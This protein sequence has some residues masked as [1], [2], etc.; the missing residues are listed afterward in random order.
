MRRT[1]RN[2]S[3]RR[4]PG[5]RMRFAGMKRAYSNAVLQYGKGSGEAKELEGRISRLSGNSGK[6]GSG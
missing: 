1:L 6:T 4:S 3:P 2:V 5:R